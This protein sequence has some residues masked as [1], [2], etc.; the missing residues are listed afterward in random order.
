MLAMLRRGGEAW[1]DH[2]ILE[3]CLFTIS[4]RQYDSPPS[5]PATPAHTSVGAFV[6][7]FSYFTNA[8]GA[9]GGGAEGGRGEERE[10]VR[11]GETQGG[12][13]EEYV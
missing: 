5:H 7:G 2:K 13:K 10:L 11:V 12:H 9:G 3:T 4:F 8:W 6:E 1:L